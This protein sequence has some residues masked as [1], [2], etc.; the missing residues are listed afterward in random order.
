[1]KK[2]LRRQFIHYCFGSAFIALAALG[3][4]QLAL[5][6]LLLVFALGLLFSFLIK[7]GIKIPL[8]FQVAKMVERDYEKHLPGKGALLF[9]LSA[10]IALGV[11]GV[12][13]QKPLAALGALC[14]VVYGDSASTMAG[15]RFGK[16]RLVGK[17]T[18]EG[19]LGGLAAAFFFLQ[20]LFP[21]HIALIAAT[22][23]MI[24][25]LLPWDDNFTIPLAAGAALALLS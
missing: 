9:F 22:V 21:M 25:E 11:F 10:I 3:G 24:A 5:E 1:M 2:E 19:T 20:F 12:L 8:F 14:A 4:V 15:L 7:K 18:W 17:R 16:H 23:G 13:L 6:I